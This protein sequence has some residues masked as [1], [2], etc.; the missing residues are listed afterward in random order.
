VCAANPA[1]VRASLT[2]LVAKIQVSETCSSEAFDYNQLPVIESVHKL[3]I[4][5][6]ALSVHKL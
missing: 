5:L 3:D 4:L 1:E 6:V 2:C